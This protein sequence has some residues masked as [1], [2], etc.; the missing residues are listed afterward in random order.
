MSY[1]D[2]KKLK[3]EKYNV[4]IDTEHFDGVMNYGEIYIKGKIKK[5]NFFLHTLVTL[6]WLTMKFL[7]L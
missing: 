4:N 7:V 2:S 5:R 1:K 6:Q 3:N